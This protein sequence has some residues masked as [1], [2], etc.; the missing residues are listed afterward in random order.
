MRRWDILPVLFFFA[1]S[2][3]S[4]V[5]RAHVAILSSFAFHILAH[6]SLT[7]F[8]FLTRNEP[9][10]DLPRPRGLRERGGVA[11]LQQQRVHRQ[12]GQDRVVMGRPLRPL[13]AN[14]LRSPERCLHHCPD[15]TC[16]RCFSRRL[17]ARPGNGH[18]SLVAIASYKDHHLCCHHQTCTVLDWFTNALVLSSLFL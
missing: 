16:D 14:F 3:S 6:F 5:S 11:A 18:L 4:L 12:W 13:R 8:L 17:F 15:G 9:I 2:F 10:T 7:R 1:P